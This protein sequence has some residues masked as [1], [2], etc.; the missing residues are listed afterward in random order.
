MYLGG[1]AIECSLK[2]LVCHR[3]NKGNLKETRAFKGESS[4]IN[5]HSLVKLLNLSPEVQSAPVL[6]KRLEAEFGRVRTALE[7]ETGR[8][9]DGRS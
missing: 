5:S 2:S 4:G 6:L 1:Y 8:T 3:E 9:R 7:A